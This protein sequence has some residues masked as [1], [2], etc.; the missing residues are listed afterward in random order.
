MY[1]FCPCTL[2]QGFQNFWNTGHLLRAF[3]G[4]AEKLNIK[5]IFNEMSMK[6]NQK[7]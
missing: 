6:F 3:G 1:V 5:G 7:F 2:V 4:G